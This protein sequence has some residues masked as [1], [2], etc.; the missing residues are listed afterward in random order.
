M[1]KKKEKLSEAQRQRLR[2]KPPEDETS[3]FMRSF[4]PSV[5]RTDTLKIKKKSSKEEAWKVGKGR[6]VQ[7]EKKVAIKPGAV[8]D[9]G[10]CDVDLCD[11]LAPDCPGCH[12]PC[13]V[14]GSCKCGHECREGR[15]WQYQSIHLDGQAE[16][17]REAPVE[18]ES[19]VKKM[20]SKLKF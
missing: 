3:L 19:K 11:C 4:D 5:R 14:C 20:E 10:V 8:H 7:G 1:E 6:S 17:L 18:M 13:P 9:E 12:F 16:V 2:L 15:P